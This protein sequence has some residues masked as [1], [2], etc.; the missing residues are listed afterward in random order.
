MFGA[1]KSVEFSPAP[2]PQYGSAWRTV[3]GRG[4]L[5]LAV[6]G[7]AAD[8]YL[9]LCSL[10]RLTDTRCYTLKIGEAANTRSSFTKTGVTMHC[11][12][13]TNSCLPNKSLGYI[14]L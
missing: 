5:V 13:F 1:G 7:A 4:Q 3:L 11:L 10:P 14:L 12:K 6:R 2:V 9:A 8:V